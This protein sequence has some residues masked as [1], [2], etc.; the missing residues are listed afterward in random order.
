LTQLLDRL[1]RGG[2]ES[3]ATDELKQL[4]R[5]YRHATIDL[6]L[7]RASGDDPEL[8]RY[9]N[10][11][12]ARAHGYVYRARK[13]SLKPLATFVTT[14]F[15]QLVRRHKIAICVASAV[16]LLSTLASFLAV[17]R[18]PELAYSLFD[19]R[20]VEFENVRLE[21]HEGEYRGNFTFDVEHS[22][23]VAAVIIGNNIKVAIFAFAAGA[24][25]CLPGVL[26]LVFNGRMLGTLTGLVWNH[27]YVV[28]FYSLIMTHGVLE[29]S[30]ICIA[31]GSGMVLG[32]ALIA[33]GQFSRRESLRR[34]AGDAFGLLAGCIILLVIAGHIEA[35][36]TPHAPAAVR[37]SVAIL[38]GVLL[39]GYLGFSGRKRKIERTSERGH[40]GQ[41]AIAHRETRSQGSD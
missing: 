17:I 30:A 29:L 39:F 3:L 40:F 37:W 5:L 18:D 35:Y 36:V 33:P 9:L 15:P 28:D 20:V 8:V 23:L 1:Q 22:P 14:G 41:L 16:F 25:Y 12:S 31:G 32:W 4:C 11:L 27:D 7:A 2:V 21:R 10:Q 26:L 34:A 6:S 19:E 24:L 13:V 38:S